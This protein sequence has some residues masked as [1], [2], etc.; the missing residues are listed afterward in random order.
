MILQ[1]C[2][3]SV[4]EQ[5]S[6]IFFLLL[7]SFSSFL[8]HLL[9][10]AKR[11]VTIHSEITDYFTAL[12]AFASG[13]VFMALPNLLTLELFLSDPVSKVQ[14]LLMFTIL[15]GYLRELVDRVPLDS[16]V[17]LEGVSHLIALVLSFFPGCISS[18]LQGQSVSIL[19]ATFGAGVVAAALV[20]SRPFFSPIRPLG[21][22]VHSFGAAGFSAVLSF[23]IDGFRGISDCLD[24][25]SPTAIAVAVVSGVVVDGVIR[26]I[27]NDLISKSGIAVLDGFRAC[28]ALPGRLPEGSSSRTQR[29]TAFGTSP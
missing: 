17:A 18:A 6:P 10:L 16:E 9:L 13:V 4:L 21:Y 19:V 24:V 28:Q 25:A 15:V 29:S 20:G 1:F 5:I 23:V 22:F 14:H 2:S 8:D 3:A 27:Q 12:P 7:A 11:K 26:A